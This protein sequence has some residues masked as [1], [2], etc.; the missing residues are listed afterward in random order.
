MTTLRIYQP[1]EQDYRNELVKLQHEINFLLEFMWEHGYQR[2]CAA[3]GQD[4]T[5]K[6]TKIKKA[7]CK[8][9]LPPMP[10]ELRNP[11]T[12]PRTPEEV[13]YIKSLRKNS[14]KPAQS[15][16]IK[17]QWSEKVKPH[18]IVLR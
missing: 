14:K 8:R 15:V 12:R 18:K 9:T 6:E 13:E 7:L 2:Y 17:Y 10:D 5:E 4:L 11:F 3:V 1:H 16:P